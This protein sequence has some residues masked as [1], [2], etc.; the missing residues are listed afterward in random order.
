MQVFVLISVLFLNLILIISM[1]SSKT[2]SEYDNHLFHDFAKW[3]HTECFLLHHTVHFF[4]G[5][6]LL[7]LGQLKSFAKSS[8]LLSD[9]IVLNACGEWVSLIIWDFRASS[10]FTAHQP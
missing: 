6:I 9:P 1:L 5:F 4:S 10:V 7:P 8:L 3:D 2:V